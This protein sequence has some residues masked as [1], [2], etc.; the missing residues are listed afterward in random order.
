[1]LKNKLVFYSLIGAVVLGLG[2]G[3]FA[4]KGKKAKF[5]K[6]KVDEQQIPDGWTPRLMAKQ[7]YESMD[8]PAWSIKASGLA[9]QGL[10]ALNDEQFKA[11]YNEFNKAYANEG[12]FEKGSLRDWINDEYFLA[13]SNAGYA[14]LERMDRLKL[15]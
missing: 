12:W 6:A 9:I 15:I 10:N 11:V 1:M 7:L 4:F 13:S 14:V 2:I 3:I 8:G 5:T